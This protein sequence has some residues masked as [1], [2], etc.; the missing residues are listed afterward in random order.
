[1]P[2]RLKS[3]WTALVCVALG[4]AG[5]QQAQ[6][7]AKTAPRNVSFLHYFSFAGSFGSTMDSVVAD[8]NRQ[9]PE[10][11]LTATPLDH[12]AFKTSIRDDLRLGNTADV[13]SYWA[14]ERVQSIA[15]TFA[16]IDDVLPADEMNK[17]FSAQVVRSACTYNGRIRLLP[18]T[19]HYVGFFYNKQI[20]AEHKL[21]PPKTWDE[22]I[23]LNEKLRASGIVPLAL[24]SKARW[25]AQFWFDYL[26]LRTAP[27]DYRQRLMAGKAS[28]NDPEVVR[29]FGVW[30]DLI[31][32]G[33]FNP[34]PN[35]LEFDSSAALM[36]RRGEAAMTL[37][38]TWLI[39]YFNDPSVVWTEENGYGF[40]PF[41]TIDPKIPPVA[42]GPIDGLVVPQAARNSAG[43]KA[44]V[45]YFSDRGVQEAISRGTGALAP[46]LEVEAEKIYSPLKME[47]AAEVAR[48]SAWAFNYDLATPPERA[49]IGLDLFAEFLEFPDQYKYLLDTAA[50]RMATPARAPAIVPGKP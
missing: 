11:V 45:R 40:F 50:A 24:G 35:E 12:E 47:V 14:G 8:F 13:Y 31:Q 27:L 36:V 28:F 5:C 39:G 49:E 16:P 48:A 15:D 37:M 38:G 33:F 41:P 6:D 34:H 21:S 19:Q 44:L 46:N 10:H 20:F 25:P 9:H 7:E 30:N 1:M 23:A 18:L 3:L 29:V 17:L 22:F 2:S 4:A 42:L 43:A 26:L 32:R